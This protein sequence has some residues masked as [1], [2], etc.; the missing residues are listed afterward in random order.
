MKQTVFWA[1]ILLP[2][3]SGAQNTLTLEECY[4]QTAAHYPLM[5]QSELIRT[6][7]A[8]EVKSINKTNLPTIQ[9]NAQATYQS[10]V[11]QVPI[12]VP[13]FSVDPPNND[14]Y[15][16]TLDVNQ[17]IYNG[18][19][20][21]ARANIKQ[22]ENN[23]QEQQIE[24]SL[25]QLK[26]EVNAYYFTI[27]QV[28]EQMALLASKSDVLAKH[29]NELQS[30]IA[31]GAVLP[32]S[33]Q[34]LKAEQLKIKQQITGLKY[35]KRQYINQL[36]ALTGDTLANDVEL[37]I[38]VNQIA[39]NGIRPELKYYDLQ[40]QQLER[41]KTLIGK[42][43]APNIYAF[44]QGGYG[45]PGLNM[46][47]NTFQPYYIVGVKLNWTVFDWNQS[48]TDRQALQV[49]QEM[50][51]NQKETFTFNTNRKLDELQQEMDKNSEIIATDNE[52]ITLREKVLTASESQ[53][54][55]GVITASDYIQELS[56][57]FEAKTNKKTHEIQLAYAQANYNITQ[58]TAQ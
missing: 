54:K 1:L 26:Q 2:F 7:N 17:V 30:G 9:L 28:Q 18:G 11:T 8:L 31:N 24:V 16:A 47:D 46:L 38:P 15:K 19:K 43:N 49:A 27:L 21:S 29:I 40:Q 4:Q 3:W 22:A 56:N 13:G 23:T 33:D 20:T 52:I 42:T 35:Q 58:G 53:F 55:N 41:S 51:E 45:N 6:K 50:V 34:I 12:E 57:L 44:A 48:K 37:Q 14:Q 32:A 36:S 5:K 39:S 10:D 25:Y